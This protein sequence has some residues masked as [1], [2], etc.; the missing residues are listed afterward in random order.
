MFVLQ[1]H[2]LFAVRGPKSSLLHFSSGE[3]SQGGN[4]FHL[5]TDHLISSLE[6]ASRTVQA[7]SFD[8]FGITEVVQ[9]LSPF[10]EN[11]GTTSCPHPPATVPWPC[12]FVYSSSVVSAAAV[13]KLSYTS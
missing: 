5:R 12:L 3:I 10:M 13:P 9:D 8:K 11:S 6:M 2:R 1:W 4:D 7:V